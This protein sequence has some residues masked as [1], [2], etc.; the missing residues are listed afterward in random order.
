MKTIKRIKKHTHLIRFFAMFVAAVFVFELMPYF[1]DNAELTAEAAQTLSEFE[2][3]RWNSILAA[4]FNGY[5]VTGT[6][7]PTSPSTIY[8]DPVKYTVK[9]DSPYFHWYET[10]DD[11]P[12]WGSETVTSVASKTET[13]TYA[14]DTVESGED[15]STITANA[16]PVTYNTYYVKNADEFVWVMTQKANSGN[17]RIILDADIDMGGASNKNWG[18]TIELSGNSWFD[19]EGEGHRIYNFRMNNPLINRSLSNKKTIIRNVLFSNCLAFFTGANQGIVIGAITSPVY[20]ENVSVTDSLVYSNTH[21]A[22]ILIGRVNGYTNGNIFLKNCSTLR[23][24]IYGTSHI[25]GMTACQYNTGKYQVKYNAAFPDSP[26]VWMFKGGAVFPEMIEKCYSVDCEVFSNGDDSGAII[27]CG[28]GFICRNCF[29]NNTMYGN[30]RTGAF[31]GRV[32]TQSSPNASLYDDGYGRT[33]NESFINC[34]SSGSVEGSGEIGGFVAL[35]H[36]SNNVNSGACV[37]INCYS[38]AMVGMEFAGTQ[39]GGFIGHEDTYKKDKQKPSVTLPDGT[40]ST[41]YGD[42]YINCY[43]AGE[44]GNI[45]TDTST[46]ATGDSLGGFLGDVSTSGNGTYYNCY[47]DKQTTAM[48]ERACGQLNEFANK[49]VGNSQIPGVTGVYTQK[50]TA[51]NVKGLADNVCMSNDDTTW[52]YQNGFY[53]MLKVFIANDAFKTLFDD[54]RSK[55]VEEYAR[56]SV[57]TV[58]LNHYDT[59]LEDNGEERDATSSDE[60]K[61]AYDTVRDITSKFELTTN[62][63]LGITWG[64]DTEKNTSRGLADKFGGE[65][66]FS[67]D[68]KTVNQDEDNDWAY[69]PSEEN[70]RTITKKFT[71]DVLTIGRYD[72]PEDDR[73]YYYKCFDFAPGIQWLKVSA[74]DI[75]NNVTGWDNNTNPTYTDTNLVGSRSFRLLPTAYLNAGDIMHINVETDNTTSPVTYTN[76]VTIAQGADEN[77]I[78]G[79]FNHSVGVAFAITDKYRMGSDVY[80]SQSIDKYNGNTL[81]DNDHFAFYSGYAVN[82]ANTASAINNVKRS[83][84]IGSDPM[85][86]QKF[87]ITNNATINQVSYAGIKNN[88]S[89]GTVRVRIFRANA[90]EIGAG[91]GFYL[92]KGAE[93]DYEDSDTLA[94]WQGGKPFDTNDSNAYYY[95]D[96]YWRLN[97]GRYLFDRKLVRITADTYSVTMKTGLLDEQYTVNESVTPKT[98]VDQYVTDNITTNSDNTKTWDK[99]NLYPSKNG[100]FNAQ[101]APNYYEPDTYNKFEYINGNDYYTKTLKIDTASPQTAVGWMRASDY[102]LTALIVEAVDSNGMHHEM[103]R[104][105]AT[106]AEDPLN[107]DDAEY[108]YDYKT[109]SVTQ[110]SETKIFSVT[111]NTTVTNTFSVETY[112]SAVTNGVSKFILFSFS[113]T[114]DIS[115]GF[116]EIKDSLIITAL[117]RK[118]DA[119][120]KTEKQVLANTTDPVSEVSNTKKTS[121]YIDNNGV[122]QTQTY[123]SSI[124]FIDENK[125]VDDKGISD[126]DKRKAVLSGDTLTY[127]LKAYNA[128]YF[129]SREVNIYDDIPSGTTYVKDSAKLYRQKSLSTSHFDWYDEL[130]FIDITD[131]TSEKGYSIEYDP[132]SKRISADI[133]NIALDENYY[134]EYK[135]TVDDI[136]ATELSKMITNEANYKFINFNGDTTNDFA[137]DSNAGQDHAIV[138]MDVAHNEDQEAYIVKFSGREMDS[139]KTYTINYYRN[140]FPENFTFKDN[141]IGIYDPDDRN[142]T[143]QVDI[144]Y[145]TDADSKK[146]GFSIR[147]KD[148]QEPAIVLSES[149]EYKVVFKGT[150]TP[151]TDSSQEIRNK[152][153]VTYSE[154]GEGEVAQTKATAISIVERLTN[155]TE[156]DVTHLY[157]D[158]DKI[159]PESDPAQTF[160]FKIERFDKDDMS[161]TPEIS[162]TKINCTTKQTEDNYTGSRLLQLDK[163]GYYRITEVDD[164]SNSDYL[165]D[166][167]T[168]T[169]IS[170]V[171]GLTDSKTISTQ[172]QSAVIQ[173]PRQYNK[174]SLAFPTSFG[175]LQTGSYPILKFTNKLNDYA[176]RTSQAYAENLITI[177]TP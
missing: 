45:L 22:G 26:E 168:C 43:A 116:S 111:E 117:F 167:I 120:V 38:T 159:I 101:T 118:N 18:K 1:S 64:K 138:S 162:Y 131:I 157:V 123:Y 110:D 170:K 163:R 36:S 68:Y 132:T 15:G 21:N 32:V 41:N 73:G 66:G 69:L 140:E 44:V 158:I 150:A 83:K 114:G 56:A 84:N 10:S 99:D 142:I 62:D 42:V 16:V 135:V 122:T 112:S 54:T 119:N 48:R 49:G 177:T 39:L 133:P 115:E 171:S 63:D 19:L 28:D 153:T 9:E 95:L 161:D 8:N 93:I 91:K 33:L 145:D 52:E 75:E 100:G 79:L 11:V 14:A 143:N 50:S 12:K 152:A 17:T 89:F 166:E 94:K 81:T 6:A 129:T 37:Y 139:L 156:T 103:S 96:Y 29:T 78:N 25:G 85:V 82:D 3:F 59:I 98:A 107:F 154:K 130:E 174:D 55:L 72:D 7:A 149:N 173:F 67:L 76:T 146:T 31:I 47:Y 90:K 58:L 124:D 164:W 151:L 70:E 155:Q 87:D 20:L 74:G 97:D 104:I 121:T 71:P 24:Y 77:K 65:N 2:K 106:N 113:T 57:A 137:T 134:L 60:D 128:G 88:S 51:K 46:Q 35:Q 172:N 160:L 108:T 102:K 80:A 169:D 125:R 27:S 105:D 5:T 34:F 40:Q 176:Y 175:G 61:K 86:S 109:Y 13:I 92:E 136:K 141:S 4:T 144:E 126:T 53:P 23:S 147:N 148:G 127:R 165:F 30:T